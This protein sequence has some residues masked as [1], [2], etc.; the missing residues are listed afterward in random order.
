MQA[1]LRGVGGAF[2]KVSGLND[3]AASVW[4]FGYGSLIW[5]PDFP[6]A[7]R[8]PARITGWSRRFWQGSH[9][10]R[11]VPNAPGRVATL[12]AQRD[13][14]CDG[15]A[16]R[17]EHSVF[18]HLD[19]RE[20]NGYERHA[21]ALTFADGR[22]PG[23]AYIAPPDNPAYLGTASLDTIARQILVSRGPSGSNTE[24]LFELAEALRELDLDDPH[25]FELEARLKQLKMDGHTPAA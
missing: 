10:H 5:R 7:E 20:K 14:I 18:D 2:L 21:V 25:V 13:A 11:G 16:Y 1:R 17:I 8:K 9:D 19:H 12:I 15:V 24:Y 3:H 6:F 23:V 22:A 4:I